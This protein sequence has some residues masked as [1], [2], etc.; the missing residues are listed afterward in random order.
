M[1]KIRAA[2]VTGL[3]VALGLGGATVAS[4]AEAV[5]PNCK[6]EVA[7]DRYVEVETVP[8]ITVSLTDCGSGSLTVE[9]KSSSSTRSVPV[10]TVVDGE[11]NVILEGV[12]DLG[13]YEV[14]AKVDAKYSGWAPFTIISW[15]TAHSAGWKPVGQTTYTWGRFDTT[16]PITVWTEVNTASGWSR[17]QQTT[18]DAKGNYTMPLTYGASTPGVYTWRVGGRYPSGQVFYSDPFILERIQTATAASAGVKVVNLTTYVW[19]KFDVSVPTAVWTEVQTASGWSRSQTA[20]TNSNGSYTIPL[21]YGANTPGVYR[22]R[23]AGD[24][25]SK[26]VLRTPEFSF[27]RVK[28][29]S[30]STAGAKRVGEETY[31]WGSFDGTGEPMSVWT[32]VLTPSGWSRSQTGRTTDSGYYSLPLTYGSNT[33]G[34]TRWRAVAQYPEGV[35][36]TGEATLRRY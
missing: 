12:S 3:A 2:F 1:G 22:W 21:T 15:P 24:I 8:E 17:S 29:P 14:R 10:G 31:A 16:T 36:T 6:V 11:K 35:L 23:V 25:D 9:V 4:Q 20:T 7:T 33:A 5:G 19:G 13:N 27:R 30:I 34:T 18:T 28:S 32:E 26:T